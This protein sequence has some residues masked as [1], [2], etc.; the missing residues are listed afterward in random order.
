MFF[1]TISFSQTINFTDN[2]LKTKLLQAN[3]N[4]NIASNINGNNIKIDS[5]NNYEIEIEEA[6]TVYVLNISFSNISDLTGLENFTNLGLLDISYNQLTHLNYNLANNLTINASHNQLSNLNIIG[7]MYSEGDFSYNDIHTVIFTNINVGG[8]P[9]YLNNNSISS[10]NLNGTNTIT[11]SLNLAYNNIN[12]VDITGL[13][14]KNWDQNLILSNNPLTK[15]KSTNHI[16]STILLDN[17]SSTTL[18]LTEYKDP[19]GGNTDYEDS[20]LKLTNCN[21]LNTIYTKNDFNFFKTCWQETPDEIVCSDNV[22]FKIQN[23]PNLNTICTDA[24]EKQYIQDQINQQGLQNQIVVS[25]NCSLSLNSPNFD[26]S[27]TL[28]IYPNPSSNELNISNISNE[29][30][31]SIEIYNTLGQICL[32]SMGN[33]SEINISNLQNGTYYI[34]VITEKSLFTD[35]FIKK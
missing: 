11:T 28:I 12:E 29:I 7:T 18:D 13:E 35:Q 24:D 34:K 16:L 22:L 9:L 17:I 23:C 8:G 4:N 31:H 32:K 33:V 30:I 25:S 15:I 1:T 19:V 26:L 20:I 2:N 6:L 14:I 27:K 10:L 3:V 5:N 21:N